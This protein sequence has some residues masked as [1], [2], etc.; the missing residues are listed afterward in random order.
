MH[1]PLADIPLVRRHFEMAP[2]LLLERGE[3]TI[4]E[5][6]QLLD[7]DILEDVVV[8][9]LF[10]ILPGRIDVVEQFALQAAVFVGG[11][12][13][14]QFGHFD[15]LGRFVV[16]ELLVAQIVVRVGEKVAQRVPGG[17]EDFVTVA[18]VFARVVV[19]DVE[20]VGDV[21][22]HENLLQLLG[23]IVGTVVKRIKLYN[24]LIANVI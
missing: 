14:D 3:R 7:R 5:F 10:E 11:D 19:R 9:D 22:V 12:Q 17:H 8:D 1:Q 15:I 16:A 24:E 2:E 13:I 18:A 4:G 20:P 21:Q 6:G 23:R